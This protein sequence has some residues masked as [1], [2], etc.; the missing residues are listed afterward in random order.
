MRQIIVNKTRPNEKL[1]RNIE[2]LLDRKNGKSILELC[3]K[4]RLHP[5]TISEILQSIEKRVEIKNPDK[6]SE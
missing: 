3:F 5:K 6:S 1:E 4:Y 2:I